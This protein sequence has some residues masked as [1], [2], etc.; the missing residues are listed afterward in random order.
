MMTRLGLA[1]IR[2]VEKVCM[3]RGLCRNELRLMTGMRIVSV[4][5][6]ILM[7]STTGTAFG[8]RAGSLLMLGLWNLRA[9]RSGLMKNMMCR[10]SQLF[11]SSLELRCGAE[12]YSLALFLIIRFNLSACLPRVYGSAL[13][14]EVCWIAGLEVD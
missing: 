9:C 5:A 11:L 1:L 10:L 8:S 7:E 14:L 3:K 2:F 12:R 6:L 13:G 4:F